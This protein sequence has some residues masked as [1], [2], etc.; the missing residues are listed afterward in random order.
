VPIAGLCEWTMRLKAVGD[1]GQGETMEGGGQWKVGGDRGWGAMEGS[2]QWKVG[3]DRGWG[4][5]E[6]SGQWKVGGDGEQVG[7]EMEGGGQWRNWKKQVLIRKQTTVGEVSF[8]HCYPNS[9]C[10]GSPSQ[11]K[12]TE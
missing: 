7:G 9:A 5:M 1:G 2:G 11:H 10:R 3:G 8:R 4:A 12:T 6:G